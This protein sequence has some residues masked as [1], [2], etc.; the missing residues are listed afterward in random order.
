M[1][2]IHP[3][4]IVTPGAVMADDVVIGPYCVVGENVRLG[5]CFRCYFGHPVKLQI[6]EPSIMA[7][8]FEQLGVRSDFFDPSQIHHY[9]LIGR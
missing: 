1:P 8:F 3:T 4:A 9:D 2:Q 7:G 5:R 6:V